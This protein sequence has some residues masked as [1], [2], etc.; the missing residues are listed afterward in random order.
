[1]S[2]T[3]SRATRRIAPLLTLISLGLPLAVLGC[4]DENDPATWVKRLDDPATRAQAVSRLIQF[5]ED[6]VTQDKRDKGVACTADNASSICQSRACE[7]DN[8]CKLQVKPLL[9]LVVEPLTQRCVAADLDD[10]TNSKLIKLLSDTR[11]PKAEPCLIKTL[12]DYKMDQTEE[13]VRQVCRAVA[14]MK[15][16]SAAGPLMEVFTKIKASKPKAQ[17]IYRDVHD[18][19]V[20]LEEQSWEPQL[21]SLVQRPA[22][23][24][25]QNTFTDEMFWQITAA[26]ILGN[27]KSAAAVKPLLKLML[28]PQKGAGQGDAVLALVKIG[29]PAIG[30]TIALL[31]GEDKELI[32][33]SKGEVLKAAGDKPE[34]KKNA[35]KAAPTAHVGAAALVLATIGREETSA[36][37]VEALGKADSDIAKAIMARELTKVPKTPATVKAFQDTY[38]KLPVTLSIPN[39][40]GGAREVLLDVAPNFFDA[41]FV[42]WIAKTVKEMKGSDDDLDP[43][44]AKALEATIKL[45][46]KDQASYI[47]ALA[48]LKSGNATLGK[49]YEKEIKLAKSLLTDCSDKVDCLLGKLTDPN[50]NTDDKV[51][52]GVK[53]AYQIG[54]LDGAN[55]RGKI[56]A[57]YPKISH[58]SIRF[59]ALTVVDAFSPKGD[60]AVAAQ[61]QKV[62]DDANAT[63]DADKMRFNPALKQFIYRLNA[64]A[65]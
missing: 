60:T 29:K 49:E 51:S 10:R 6:K 64:R 35:E 52:V 47:D 25:D 22:D 3:V 54:E 46:T 2:R 31:R 37:L 28:S 33:F 53:A 44:R 42:P 27:L 59:A 16:K 38:E 36:P 14:A 19:V 5:Y 32:D 43:I 50:V 20:A 34:D 58:P 18:A 30:P 8:T 7:A 13:D 21:I 26:E 4:A 40:R 57:A 12:K 39:S 62:V 9:D 15:L 56:M 23:Q 65:Q 24:K 41:S 48:G 63:H 1:M 61:L 55:S 11:D 17:P 45:A